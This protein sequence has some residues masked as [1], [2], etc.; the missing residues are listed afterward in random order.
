V[1]S[2]YACHLLGCSFNALWR[3]RVDNASLTV[4]APPR[5]VTIND[6]AHLPDAL[7]GPHLQRLAVVTNGAGADGGPW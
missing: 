2:V 1:I 7:R 5:L 4:V 3:L 6:T